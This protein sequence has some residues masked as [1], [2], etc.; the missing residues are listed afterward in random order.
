MADKILWAKTAFIQFNAA[1]SYIISDSV[2]NAEKIR[3]DIFAKIQAIPGSPDKY[4]PDKYKKSSRGN[5]R[6]FEM[7]HYRIACHTSKAGI[8]ILRVRHTGME[9]KEY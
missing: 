4:P 8:K 5:Y 6:A 9:P 2:Q 1:I 7:H 3:T